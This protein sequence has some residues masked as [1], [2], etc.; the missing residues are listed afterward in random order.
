M[1]KVRAIV[2]RSPG[3]N[4]DAESAHALELAGAKVDKVHVNRLIDKAVSLDG[5]Q[6]M[7]VPGGF[8]YGDDLGSGKILANKL[9]FQLEREL[10]KFI[11][12]GNLVIAVCNGFQIMVKARFLPGFATIDA[13]NEATL[14]FNDSGR[15]EGRWAALKANPKSNCVWAKGIDL[16]DV[17]C[18]HGEGKFVPK[19]PGV[20]SRLKKNNQIVF[21]YCDSKGNTD[22]GYPLNPNGSVEGI[23]GICNP[24]GNVLG[25]M[26]HPEC[27]LYGFNHPQW[28]RRESCSAEGAGRKIFENGVRYAEEKLV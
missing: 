27:F 19:N 28:T 4:T 25:L 8:S 17:P 14:T 18:R 10:K 22:V 23:A 13:E 16:L 6:M 15:F 3:T 21:Q 24:K 1:N 26:P 12:Q 5:Y 9:S 7:F 20:L 2:L 11:E